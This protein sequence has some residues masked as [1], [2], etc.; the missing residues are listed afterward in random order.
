MQKAVKYVYRPG[1]TEEVLRIQA[2]SNGKRP[3]YLLDKTIL[4]G[5]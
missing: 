5:L 1:G 2:K 3:S 4:A